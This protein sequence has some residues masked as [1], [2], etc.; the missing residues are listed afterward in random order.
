MA[1]ML[2]ALLFAFLFA[3]TPA[4]QSPPQSNTRPPNIVYVL[5]DELGYY[6]YSIKTE[7]Y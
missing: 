1:T 4:T 6:E 3:A 7:C 2:R 5:A